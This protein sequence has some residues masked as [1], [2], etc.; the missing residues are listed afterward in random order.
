MDRKKTFAQ[1]AALLYVVLGLHAAALYF[2]LYWNLWWYDIAVHALMGL[3]IG[4]MTL[5]VFSGR[6]RGDE[7]PPSLVRFGAPIVTVLFFGLLWETFEWNLDHFVIVL[8]QT[9]L[10]DTISDIGSGVGGGLISAISLLGYARGKQH[11]ST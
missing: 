8:F 11:G 5:F 6:A 3:W 10:T 7:A 1:L 2:F 9:D 4:G